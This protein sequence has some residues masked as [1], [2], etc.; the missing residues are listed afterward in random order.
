MSKNRKSCPCSHRTNQHE[1]FLGDVSVQVFRVSM[2]FS[3]FY[4]SKFSCTS[5]SC[6]LVSV[7][8]PVFPLRVRH[9]LCVCSSV[10]SMCPSVSCLPFLC[11]VF[12]SLSPLSVMCIH[13]CS[14]QSVM[15]LCPSLIR[16][17]HL[18]S[19]S[20]SHVCPPP[21]PSVKPVSP[22]LCFRV[23]PILF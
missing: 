10:M 6:F 3:P 22:S 21:G 1:T 2:E 20:G 14:P 11:L 15:A 7:S 12:Y 16:P 9:V 13:V 4:V 19:L 5:G 17:L 23:L 8:S 18:L